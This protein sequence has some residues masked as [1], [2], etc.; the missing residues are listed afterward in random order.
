MSLAIYRLFCYSS[1]Y[2]LEAKVRNALEINAF[3]NSDKC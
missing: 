3:N 2:K 1:A